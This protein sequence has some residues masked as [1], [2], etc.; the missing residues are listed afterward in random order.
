MSQV[1]DQEILT[2][3]ITMYD[4]G[5][6]D[7]LQYLEKFFPVVSLTYGKGVRRVKA[8]RRAGEIGCLLLLMEMPL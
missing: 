2:T 4:T 5:L 7:L 6:V 1:V 3:N 8:H